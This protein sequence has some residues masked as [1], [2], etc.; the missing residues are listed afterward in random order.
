MDDKVLGRQGPEKHIQVPPGQPQRLG[1]SSGELD[2]VA[3]RHRPTDAIHGALQDFVL[4][5]ERSCE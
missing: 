2:V 3:S 1:A 4:E 5:K